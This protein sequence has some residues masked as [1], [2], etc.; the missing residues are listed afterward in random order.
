[1]LRFRCPKCYGRVGAP[2]GYE[3][4]KAKCPYCKAKYR[5]PHPPAPEPEDPTI[6]TQ[7]ADF[8]DT[9]ELYVDPDQDDDRTEAM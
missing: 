5:I 9:T 1:M 6:T 7:E 3:G 8:T 4:R 2:A